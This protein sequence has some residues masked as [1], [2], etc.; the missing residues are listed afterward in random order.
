[1]SKVNKKI[2][3]KPIAVKE[4]DYYKYADV[5]MI[6][7][8]AVFLSF[9]T[10]F[11]ITGDDD[12]FWHLTTGK[13]VLQTH[14]V[15]STDVFGYMTQGQQWM[16]F[17]WGW[18]VLTYSI[19]SVSGLTGLS[20]FRTSMFLLI[21]YIYYL[22][23]RK[24]KVT[25]FISI[26]FL[27]TLAFAIIDRLSPRPHIMSYLS[28]SLL[29]LIIIKFRYFERSNFKILYFIPL[30]FLV[31]ANMHMGIIA[32]MFLIGIFVL[33][34]VIMYFK[35]S[36][37]NSGEIKPLS[38]PE[39]VRLLLIFTATLLVM[40]INPNFYQTYIYAYD[41]TKMKMLE[42]VNEWMSPFSSTY[43]DGFVSYLYK[44]YLFVGIIV[45]Y[46]AYK[47]K[48]I[49]SAL[50]YTGF[51]IYSVRAMRFTVDYVLILFVFVVITISFLIQNIKSEQIKSI[52]SNNI[53]LK[54]GLTLYL[55]Y[56]TINVSDNTLYLKK[57]QYYRITGFGI[58]SDFIPTQMFDFMKETKITEKS[59]KIFNHFGTGGFFIWNFPGKQ[60]FI[61]SRNLND[62]IF[63]KYNKLIAKRPGFEQK[64][65]E[66][67]IEYS[68]YLAPDL[69][70]APQEMEQTIISYFSKHK[71]WKLIFWDDKS[72][73]FVKN[74]P[75]FNDMITKY[76][77]DYI[78]PYNVIY[79]KNM[80]EK[81]ITENK[82]KVKEELNR[83]NSEEPNGV[84]INTVNKQYSNKINN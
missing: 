82:A 81:G 41:H 51:A 33:S 16:P 78:T 84:I 5:L 79:Q 12:V 58:N 26:L 43:S 63:Y 30:I 2:N 77:Y 75:K 66:Y 54:L 64:L 40:F 15:P 56:L 1:M 59:D 18:D 23:L 47:K 4:P 34:E 44:G 52:L 38:K 7:C 48:D 25:N 67:G 39:L 68:I 72:F 60:N 49:F 31:W 53:I 37:Y 36:N 10:T 46:F 17:E 21:F 74:I 29:L 24:F 42:T 32:G 71:D 22:I 11:K 69:V 70:R 73:L 28:F 80:I 76:S 20:I 9:F 45:Y 14:Q 50:L 57:L 61:D 65:D 83:K 8:F 19:Y 55:I 35:S 27:L 62:D 3:V 6:L 13:Y